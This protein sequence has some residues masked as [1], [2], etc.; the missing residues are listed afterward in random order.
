VIAL[1]ANVDD[2]AEYLLRLLSEDD[3]VAQMGLA[4]RLHV[5]K[6]F[7]YRTVAGSMAHLIRERVPAANAG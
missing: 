2:L 5:E 1:R 3:L 6:N 4:A 7:D